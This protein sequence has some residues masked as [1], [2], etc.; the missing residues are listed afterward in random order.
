MFGLES[1]SGSVQ[2]VAVVGFVFTEAMVVYAVYGTLS[3]ALG[4]AVIDA[5]GGT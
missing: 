4:S 5:V 1:L 2:A 3:S